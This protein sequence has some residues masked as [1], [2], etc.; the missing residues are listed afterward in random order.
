MRALQSTDDATAGPRRT[1][2]SID[3]ER[4]LRVAGLKIAARGASVYI[5]IVSGMI[6]LMAAFFWYKSA[7]APDVRAAVSYNEWAALT[8]SPSPKV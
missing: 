3:M 4:T 1:R 5:K 7:I 8:P 2:A 6:G